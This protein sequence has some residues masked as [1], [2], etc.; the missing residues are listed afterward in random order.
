MVAAFPNEPNVHYARGVLRTTESPDGALEDFRR[1][2]EIS[3]KHVP[4]RLQIVFELVK[5]GEAAAAKATAEEAVSLDPQHFAPHL[6]LGQVWLETGETAK[7]I[8]EFERGV[9]L[10]P[11]SPQAHFLLARGYSRAGRTADAERER[12]IFQKLERAR[13]GRPGDPERPVP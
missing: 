12:Q 11:S 7:A 4:A 8:A 2:L 1:E 6:A 13:P 9:A 10:A 3:P 5:R